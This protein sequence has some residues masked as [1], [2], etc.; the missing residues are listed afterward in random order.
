MFIETWIGR[1]GK[2]IAF[3]QRLQL[4]LHISLQREFAASSKRWN[5]FPHFLIWGWP[6][7]VLS[8]VKV[9]PW[10]F[11]SRPLGVLP[12]DHHV[13]QPGLSQPEVQNPP[14]WSRDEMIP[15]KSPSPPSWQSDIWEGARL[16]PSRPS[17]AAGWLR[18]QRGSQFWATVVYALPTFPGRPPGRR[19]KAGTFLNTVM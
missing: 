9:R 1:C 7:D 6:C 2:P 3:K 16:R 17:W 18:L 8:P 14:M 15:L 11:C 19:R 4:T 13:G 5:L 12:W 10:S